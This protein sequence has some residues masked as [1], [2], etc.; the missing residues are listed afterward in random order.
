MLVNPFAVPGLKRP[1]DPLNPVR[2]K[3][4][5]HY[6]VDVD[7]TAEAFDIFKAELSDPTS[8][9]T[10]GRLVIVA[11]PEQ[12]GKSALV[13]R[14]AHW[15]RERLMEVHH[16]AAVIDLTRVV[17]LTETQAERRRSVCR[18]LINRLWQTGAVTDQQL[19]DFRAEP[20]DAYPYLAGAVQERFVAI[21]LLPPSGELARELVQYA[22]DAQ[23]KI[24]FFGESSYTSYVETAWPE[25]ER[26]GTAPPI[27]L[28]VGSL[29]KRDAGRFADDRLRRSPHGP[30]LP[31]VKPDTLD[32]V[33]EKRPM[34]IG[35]L[36]TL[37][38]GLYEELRREPGLTDEVTYQY[39]SEFYLRK[40]KLLG[41]RF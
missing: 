31:P 29:T 19:L 1:D 13:N 40:A 25:L 32:L 23:A 2:E 20:D 38:Y 39:I 34:S 24:L 36:Q 17:E 41:N 27:Y 10:D 14:C 22:R 5:T 33:T 30:K 21:V 11:G 28:T 12:C 18:T 35:E 3:E 6:Y 7:N 15:V 8:L 37:L 4:H 16:A 26:A 9:V